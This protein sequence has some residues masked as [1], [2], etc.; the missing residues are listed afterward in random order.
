MLDPLHKAVHCIGRFER[1]PFGR[2]QGGEHTADDDDDFSSRVPCCAVP[3][4]FEEQLRLQFACCE[5]NRVGSYLCGA[6]C[7]RVVQW[8]PVQG[9]GIEKPK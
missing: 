5:S 4:S 8:L 7:I 9:G 6:S 2:S 1:C 3:L